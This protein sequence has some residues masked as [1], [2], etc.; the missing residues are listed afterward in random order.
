MMQPP[1]NASIWGV[2]DQT[3]NKCRGFDDSKQVD[4]SQPNAIWP[5]SD[6]VKDFMEEL[7][8]I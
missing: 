4:I 6:N 5:E 3:K 2:K 8:D 1:A 7:K